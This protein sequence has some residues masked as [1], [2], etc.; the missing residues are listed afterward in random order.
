MHLTDEKIYEYLDG[1]I[2]SDESSFVNKHLDSCQECRK[3]LERLKSFEAMLIAPIPS[4]EVIS[5]IG[6]EMFE[7]LES[8][9]ASDGFLSVFKKTF[10]VSFGGLATTAA[11]FVMI[12][13]GTIVAL[14]PNSREIEKIVPAA[15]SNISRDNIYKV[16]NEN[17]L[18]LEDHIRAI[19]EMG[20]DVVLEPKR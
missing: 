17:E 20:Y 18:T 11:A 5:G 15:N 7:Q 3:R 2:K 1:E 9:K 14:N 12:M 19:E 6:N 8:E 13:I 4:D 16:S 10:N